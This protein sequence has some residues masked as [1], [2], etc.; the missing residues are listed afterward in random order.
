MLARLMLDAVAVT[1]ASTAVFV[2]SVQVDRRELPAGAMW[3]L[4][5]VLLAVL[6]AAAI[7][8][9]GSFGPISTAI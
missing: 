4:F 5:V 9:F 7:N 6:I 3:L 8:V 2:A 1:A